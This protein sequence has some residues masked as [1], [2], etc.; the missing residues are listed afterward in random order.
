MAARSTWTADQV[1]ATGPPGRKSVRGRLIQGGRATRKT[2]WK[3]VRPPFRR[4]EEVERGIIGA[5]DGR[6]PCR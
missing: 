3:F 1:P 4:D 2:R 6:I 5:A